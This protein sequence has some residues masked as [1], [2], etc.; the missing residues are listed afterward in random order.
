MVPDDKSSVPQRWC[1]AGLRRLLDLQRKEVLALLSVLGLQLRK[2]CRKDKLVVAAIGRAGL[3]VATGVKEAKEDV[4][5]AN[6]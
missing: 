5:E 6:N 2:M 4:W 3:V 1:K